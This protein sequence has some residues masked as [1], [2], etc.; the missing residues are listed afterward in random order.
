MI[1]S[2]FDDLTSG[3]Y[4]LPSFGEG[5]NHS[6]AWLQLPP[7][8]MG[9]STSLGQTSSFPF[10]SADL[11]HH[12]FLDMMSV[13]SG[14]MAPPP[15]PH[16][17]ANAP[18]R[19]S[20]EP[21]PSAEVLAAASVLQNGASPRTPATPLLPSRD[22]PMGHSRQHQPMDS[23]RRPDHS[24]TYTSN[25]GFAQAQYVN[26]FP[27]LLYASAPV[28]R[29][30]TAS[31]PQQSRPQVEIQWGSDLRFG[32]QSFMPESS[33]ETL[34]AISK[35]QLRYIECLEP[36]QSATTTRLPTPND[37]VSSHRAP[38]DR[39]APEA[40][41]T[42]EVQEGPPR[43]RRKSRNTNDDAD[44]EEDDED[45]DMAGTMSKGS[46]K[47]KSK[48]EVAT[49]SESGAPSRRRKPGAAAKPPRENLTEAQKRENHIRSEQKR[50]TI[51][52]EGFDD[53][54]ELVPG[55][56]GG[57]FSKST[58]LT[59]AAEWLEDMLQG[60]EQLAAQLSALEGRQ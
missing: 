48:N 57:G 3:H 14:L 43:K 10:P 42:E 52:K 34:D 21:H 22:I 28:E 40:T 47:R 38:Q 46:R 18:P 41:R 39:Q 45:E 51:I 6:D 13:G 17:S 36:S 32:S 50:R 30:T 5:L 19:S 16:A 15:P 33:R 59:M 9:T 20:T 55:L 53:L 7:Q 25:S 4:N 12:D 60:N 27:D 24:N 35:D 56:K 8:F 29:Q 2:F 11:H 1:S 49:A 26:A 23:F 37:E 54:C 58:I 44:D 31:S